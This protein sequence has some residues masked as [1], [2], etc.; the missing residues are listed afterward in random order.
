MSSLHVTKIK[1]RHPML[2]DLI[3]YYWIIKS[4]NQIV[5]NHKLLPVNNIDIILNFS[6][7]IKY[8]SENNTEIVTK[9]AHFNGI[10]DNYL[11]INQ[12]GKVDVIGIS[13]FSAGL[14]PL[15]KV[16]L[17]EFKNKTIELDTLINGFTLKIE[18]K[19]RETDSI[20]GKID[21]IEK[22]LVNIIGTELILD[23]KTLQMFNDFYTNI[24]KYTINQFCDQ[25]GINQRQLE[26]CFK[27]HIGISPKF[28]QRL[29]RH[30]KTINTMLHNRIMDSTRSES[31]V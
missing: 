20:V 21:V 14:Y 25:Y 16:P 30:Q 3:K 2:R 19:I 11:I 1:A 23:S 31:V 17:S 22:E 8:I 12:A 29:S 28:Y 10:R 4:D 13:F 24:E 6:S 9:K 18:N 15:I 26:R 27:K 7:P 5:V